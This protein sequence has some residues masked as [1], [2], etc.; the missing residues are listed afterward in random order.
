[1]GRLVLRLLINALALW[2][3]V[4]FVP[5]LSFEG[6]PLA[7]FG[8]AA[9]FGVLNAFVRPVLKLLTCPLLLLTLG[10]FTFILNAIMLALTAALSEALGLQFRAPLFLPAF[11]G[12]LVVSFV[13]TV[14]SL[15]LDEGDR[16]R[17]EDRER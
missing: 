8:V 1:M 6:S 4:R 2:A 3:A 10:L 7:L 15:V 14:L 9:V 13:S 12:A 17:R 16:G 5:G 11:L